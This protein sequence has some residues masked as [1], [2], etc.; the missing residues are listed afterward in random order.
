MVHA[1]IKYV[2]GNDS[3]NITTYKTVKW[4]INIEIQV[5][6]IALLSFK[7]W[8]IAKY[9]ICSLIRYLHI[10]N[11]SNRN[12]PG[13]FRFFIVNSWNITCMLCPDSKSNFTTLNWSSWA[14]RCMRRT[15]VRQYCCGNWSCKEIWDVVYQLLLTHGIIYLVIYYHVDNWII[16]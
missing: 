15:Y 13:L 10:F 12:R 11:R 7:F 9:R 5:R 3:M 2:F 1:N 16:S 14:T 8:V 4:I 6:I